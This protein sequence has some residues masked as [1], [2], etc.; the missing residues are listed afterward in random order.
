[1]D[2]NSLYIGIIASSIAIMASVYR[3]RGTI[4]RSIFSFILWYLGKR[5]YQ[6]LLSDLNRVVD[7][8]YETLQKILK[9]NKDMV[10][11]QEKGISKLIGK[12]REEFVSSLPLTTY[13]NYEAYIDRIVKGEK[14]VL[15]KD[16][17]RFATT[18]G[19]SGKQQ[20]LIPLCHSPIRT[21]TSYYIATLAYI[22]SLK[23]PGFMYSTRKCIF[24]GY[25]HPW[26]NTESG[27]KM[28][29]T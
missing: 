15:I 12:S 21:Y 10:F 22:P 4:F 8:Q 3:Y 29:L 2:K 17:L 6:K 14:N 13:Y 25:G 16:V 11:S 7:V 23:F 18:S 19:T 1:M 27:T 9:N 28:A 5:A 20:K 26:T 24:L